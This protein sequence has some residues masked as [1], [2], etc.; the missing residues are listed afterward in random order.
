M[1]TKEQKAWREVKYHEKFL[2]AFRGLRVFWSTT[3]NLYVHIF[4]AL[5]AVFFG[6]Y[7]EISG[8]EWIALIFAISFVFVSEAFNTAIEIDIDLTSPEYHPF[9]RDTKDVAAAAVLLAV[10][11]AIIIGLII[12]LPKIFI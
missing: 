4:V 6:F 2:N 5:V 9:A 8:F 12:F 1:E 11:T 10:F 7:F 3:R